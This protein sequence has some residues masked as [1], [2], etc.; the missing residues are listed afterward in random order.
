MDDPRGSRATRPA[1]DMRRIS[2]R[3]QR[4]S[5]STTVA[6]DEVSLSVA[7]GELVAVVGPSGC[8]KTTLLR[9]LAGLE[10]PDEGE[11]HIDG[12]AVFDSARRKF[13]PPERREIGMMF[14]S[15]ALWPHMTVAQNVGYPLR[16][17]GVSGRQT[18]ARVSA[19]LATVGL[20]GLENEPPN[21]L[22]GGQQ[23][24]V[25]LAR[26]L[27]AEPSVVLF[28]EPLS[29]VDAR[30]REELRLELVQI[31]TKLGFSGLYVTHDQEDAMEVCDR[32]V[33]LKGGR[34]EQIGTPAEVYRAPRTTYVAEF[35]G[36]VNRVGVSAAAY[37]GSSVLLTSDLGRLVAAEQPAT[38]AADPATD[39]TTGA[40]S[41]SAD[42]EL[43]ALIRPE[44][45]RL[46]A[47]QAPPEGAANSWP[48]TVAF[49]LFRGSWMQYLVR[50]GDV[51]LS[52]LS[53]DHSLRPGTAVVVSV[54]PEHVM[55]RS[56]R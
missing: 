28:D 52:V 14:Q 2:K 7:P 35:V 36:M 25:A 17:R 40:A 31:H 26:S 11:I 46:A 3:F 6:I 12:K 50:I 34:I 1:I 22:S 47:G 8:G 55:V 48:G 29:N 5:G 33:V 45:V 9:C 38:D 51:E 30:V 4:V 54:A 42:G 27:V 16:C 39:T 32:L 43:T 10:R 24:R 41:G 49:S 20:A 23:Q 15:Y 44:H 21:R 19:I 18:A 53:A 56:A 13:T 37:E